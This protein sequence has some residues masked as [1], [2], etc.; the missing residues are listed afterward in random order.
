MQLEEFES[1]RPFLYHLTA[2]QNISPIARLGEIWSSS[3][4]MLNAG[5][6]NLLRERRTNHRPLNCVF[7]SVHIRDQ[8]PL[9]SGNIQLE[10]GYSFEDVVELINSQVF[11]WPGDKHGPIRTGQNHYA[12]YKKERPSVVRVPTTDL[13]KANPATRPQFCK[14]NSG[15]P[16]YS[17]GKPSPRGPYQYLCASKFSWKPSEVIEFVVRERVRLPATAEVSSTIHGPWVRLFT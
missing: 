17:Y 14:F 15:A 8:A 5:A 7:G 12:R 6:T 9:H 4:L 11:F 13:L 2:T 16:R 1:S 3:S 10:G